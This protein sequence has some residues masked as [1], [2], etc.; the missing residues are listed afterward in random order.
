MVSPPGGDDPAAA[1]QA[2]AV[3]G[4]GGGGHRALRKVFQRK[5]RH[6]GQRSRAQAGGAQMGRFRGCHINELRESSE[7]SERLVAMVI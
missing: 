1:D 7:S 4:S 3:S 6:V 2:G 5:A